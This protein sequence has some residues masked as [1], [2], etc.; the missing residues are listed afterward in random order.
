[1][2]SAYDYSLVNNGQMAYTRP[3][4]IKDDVNVIG[5]SALTLPRYSK[6]D[7]SYVSASSL[8]AYVSSQISD[9]S[10]NF[11][12][13][14]HPTIR[15]TFSRPKNCSGLRLRFN[16]HTG[17]H[18]DRGLVRWY[19]AKGSLISESEIIAAGTDLYLYAEVSAFA[20]VEVI[21]HST[22]KPYRPVF[23][24]YFGFVSLRAAETLKIIYDGRA[25]GA[26]ENISLES[27]S[28]WEKLTEAS[29]ITTAGGSDIP[30]CTER[31][32]KLD[33]KTL[34][35]DG[36]KTLSGWVSQ[37]YSN[38]AG[39]FDVP[40][41]LTVSFADGYY[42]ATGVNLGS[43]WK[44]ADI[45]GEVHI[46][47][48]R[49]GDE[50]SSGDF[51][52]DKTQYFCENVV[53]D[54][55]GLVMTFKS[56]K[57]P[58]RPVILTLIE[59]GKEEIYTTDQISS[60]ETLSEIS[61]LSEELSNNSLDFSLKGVTKTLRFQKQQ[62]LSLWFDGEKQG[63]FYVQTGTQNSHVDYDVYAEDAVSL[64]DETW[65]GY[66]SDLGTGYH[67]W[68]DT[69]LADV[70]D[71]I[72]QDTGVPY[73]VEESIAD[74]NI[75]G[76]LPI[77]TRREA[78]QQVAFATGAIVDTF[79]SD[80][81]RVIPRNETGEAVVIENGNILKLSVEA[82]DDVSKVVLTVHDFVLESAET[83]LF[84]SRLAEGTHSVTFNDP[85]VV[86]GST[87]V[88]EEYVPTSINKAFVTPVDNSKNVVLTGH[89]QVDNQVRV[90]QVNPK[91]PAAKQNQNVIK[92]EN[93]YFV[94]SGNA[95][96]VLDRVYQYYLKRKKVTAEIVGIDIQPGDMVSLPLYDGS[97]YTG[98]VERVTS[99]YSS[100]AYREVVVR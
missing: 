83:E 45:V 57:S 50:I 65:Y 44:L 47:W 70:V 3:T 91:F 10:G 40:P 88:L 56:T 54:F 82:L 76:Y 64:L 69:R 99:T 68:F 100:K 9:A 37:E 66:L 94:H 18:P 39:V 15:A 7:G 79:G 86:T 59:L 22:S 67:A 38:A 61:H 5:N 53:D 74:L 19:S 14:S 55:N 97:I 23:V 35:W 43:G 28:T 80:V 78:L 92:I 87:N 20:T 4:L 63:V 25:P 90:E 27:E 31:Y 11:S 60:N 73:S 75:R 84:D 26:A 32:S 24:E 13:G 36:E 77:C 12:S 6:L 29:Y 46:Q 16:S 48:L 52:P 2:I 95:A 58:H 98:M 96:E 51:Y 49:D 34:N 17:D 89:R 85:C 1:M 21:F 93:A 72:L 42:T 71:C 41:V 8:R 33:G 30:L 81:I 62:G